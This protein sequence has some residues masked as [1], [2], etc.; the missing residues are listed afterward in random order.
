M[1][2]SQSTRLLFLSL[3]AGCGGTVDNQVRD[4]GREAAVSD[5]GTTDTG[6]TDTGVA[7]V[8]AGP[9]D[10]GVVPTD[11]GVADSGPADTGT[12][13][14][15]SGPMDT[16]VIAMDTGPADT[17][18][19]DTGPADTGPVDT[20]V[21]PPDAGPPDTGPSCVAPQ[22]LCGGQCVNTQTN[23]AHCGTCGNACTAP[24][25]GSAT[26]TN[27]T[28]GIACNA[29]FV[30]SG[31]SCVPTQRSCTSPSVAGCGL[32]DIPA[33][34]YTMG[35]D[36]AAHLASIAQSNVS[37]RAFRLDRYP[38]TVARF[39]RFWEATDRPTGALTVPYQANGTTV[40]VVTS[41][42]QTSETSLQ[43]GSSD[44]PHNWGTAGRDSHPMNCVNWHT[45][46]AFCVWDGGRL[47]TEAEREWA[48]R[49]PD[50]RQL[51]WGGTTQD[52]ARICS[53][54]GTT[55]TTTCP[56]DDSSFAQGASTHGVHHLVGNVWE[57]VADNWSVYAS[58]GAPDPCANRSSLTNPLC[59]GSGGN[60]SDRV[61]RGGAW[62]NSVGESSYLRSAS[63]YY[64]SPTLRINSGV[65]F[66][67]ARDIP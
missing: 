38:V 66:R 11:L 60:P 59:T 22:A 32:V 62:N 47:P 20:G 3:V 28:C 7:P 46:M 63:R 23:P 5:T 49:A 16:G 6:A 25:N 30:A 24:T 51:P 56:V 55:R 41:F 67:C 37:V 58:T 35:G 29:G 26:C 17:G 27:G 1:R 53:R 44:N 65:G 40:Q 39:R 10:T 52:P 12:V 19:V 9:A 13:V 18:P 50:G 64:D 43:C 54:L 42:S 57:W 15:D 48:A 34:R 45:A 21:L 61:I 36:S 31:G 2:L 14:V 8:D 4:A 33:G